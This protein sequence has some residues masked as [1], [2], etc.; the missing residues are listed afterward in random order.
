M[1]NKLEDSEEDSLSDELASRMALVDRNS[2]EE[3]SSSASMHT[4][5]NPAPGSSEFDGKVSSISTFRWLTLMRMHKSCPFR[6]GKGNI[7]IS[8]EA[9]LI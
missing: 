1:R 5:M 2:V 9:S 8:P 4:F 7:F 3:E 6:V